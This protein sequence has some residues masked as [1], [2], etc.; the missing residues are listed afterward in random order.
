MTATTE[1]A[2]EVLCPWCLAPPG[3]ECL[4]SMGDPTRVHV[5][6]LNAFKSK[7]TVMIDFEWFCLVMAQIEDITRWS[8]VDLGE[9]CPLSP[10]DRS[11]VAG[12]VQGTHTRRRN[13]WLNLGRSP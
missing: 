2:M 11:C 8:G 12:L 1:Y 6:R 5:S 4:N 10:E 9:D 3:E 13:S 7:V